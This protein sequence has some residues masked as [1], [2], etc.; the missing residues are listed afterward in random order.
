MRTA[1]LSDG[2][3]GDCPSEGHCG[4]VIGVMGQAI[5]N[6]DDTTGGKIIEREKYLIYIFLSLSSHR[7]NTR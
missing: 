4:F 1:D 5:Q 7:N 6:N 2:N 3:I